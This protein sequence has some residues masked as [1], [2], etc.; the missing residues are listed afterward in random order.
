MAR[1]TTQR[2]LLAAFPRKSILENG[3]DVETEIQYFPS[4]Q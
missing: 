2:V 1:V 3:Y 4:E